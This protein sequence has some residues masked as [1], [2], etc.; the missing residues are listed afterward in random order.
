MLKRF[1]QD[2][3]NWREWLKAIAFA[4]VVGGIFRTFLYEPYSIPST[5]MLPTLEVTDRLF[6]SKYSYGFS[7]H[8]FFYPLPITSKERIFFS[9]PNY[10]DIIVFRGTQDNMFY[11]KRLIGLPGDTVQLKYGVVYVNG[12]AISRQPISMQNNIKIIE[13]KH[14]LA[15]YYTLDENIN[16][17]S[18]FPDTTEVYQ[19][20]ER[21]YFFLGDNR[22]NSADSRFHSMGM[23]PEENLVGKALFLYWGDS[24]NIVDCIKNWSTCRYFKKL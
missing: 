10:G 20:P 4:L 3:L 11:I 24:L 6:L 17:H 22:N 16:M 14:G 23:V 1:L 13:E 18:E 2:L 12:Q 15:Q 19:I 5:S 9:K 8:S 7:K 21:H